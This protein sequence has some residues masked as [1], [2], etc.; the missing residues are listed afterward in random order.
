MG[1]RVEKG[2]GVKGSL[3]DIVRWFMISLILLVESR[4]AYPER[5]QHPKPVGLLFP[6]LMGLQH[7]QP[8]VYP[9]LLET[10]VR[11]TVQ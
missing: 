3:E 7:P 10:H 4:H 6:Q 5:L 9:T 2:G 1:S 11:D 8:T